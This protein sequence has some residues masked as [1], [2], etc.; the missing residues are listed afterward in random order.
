MMSGIRGQDTKPELVVRRHLHAN[1]F[2]YRL[3]DRRLPGTPDLVLARH[4]LVVFV[5][6]CF[7]HQHPAC[8]YATRPAT[9]SEFWAQKL[10]ANAVRDARQSAE[11]ENLGWRIGVIWECETRR[12]ESLAEAIG[13]LPLLS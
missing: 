1:G 8:R 10:A 9:R 11:L 7:W 5:H 13:R 6:G 12:P 4:R 3:H 2:R